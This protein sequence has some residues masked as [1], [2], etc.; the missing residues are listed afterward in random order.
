MPLVLTVIVASPKPGSLSLVSI[1]ASKLVLCCG[2][3]V[4]LLDFKLVQLQDIVF[5][6][7]ITGSVPVF[8]KLKACLIG[9][10]FLISP[11]LNLS[12]LA[13]KRPFEFTIS[14]FSLVKTV[15]SFNSF[16]LQEIAILTTQKATIILIT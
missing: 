12:S 1:V 16:Y 13:S 15:F 14:T 3:I 5:S 6:K 9:V 2:A 7:I 10:P 4:S 8:L 11:A